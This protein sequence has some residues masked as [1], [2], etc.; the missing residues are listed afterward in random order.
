MRQQRWI[1]SSGQHVH[2]GR[3]LISGLH[4]QGR[5]F[6][7]HVRR[8]A[9]GGVRLNGELRV[10]GPGLHPPRSASRINNDLL[11]AA[12][13]GNA[14]S[15]GVHPFAATLGSRRNFAE[16]DGGF[17]LRL[18]RPATAHQ[19]KDDDRGNFYPAGT[20]RGPFRSQPGAWPLEGMRWSQIMKVTFHFALQTRDGRHLI[21]LALHLSSC[22]RQT[23][24]S[25]STQ[26]HSKEKPHVAR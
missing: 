23:S 6:E 19:R 24:Q 9:P 16:F 11:I 14:S 7:T 5:V 12:G 1:P 22:D 21:M 15:D 18:S 4:Q 3:R 2:G 17:E 20:V 10:I 25:E 13:S 26:G 8:G